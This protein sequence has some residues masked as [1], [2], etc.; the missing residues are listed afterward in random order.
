MREAMA[1]LDLRFGIERIP[2]ARVLARREDPATSHA[3]AARVSEFASSHQH[4]IL[5]AIQDLGDA[6][7][8]EIAR[9]CEIQAHAVGKRLI[10]LQRARQIVPTGT[11]RPGDSGRLQRVWRAIA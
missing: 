6:T 1:Q 7:V 5:A 2:A 3:A 10:E 4:R 9:H 11:E 8:D